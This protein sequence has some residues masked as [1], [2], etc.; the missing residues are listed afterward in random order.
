MEGASGPTFLGR[1]K[2]AAVQADSKGEGGKGGPGYLS[3]LN[4]E[5][6]RGKK[7]SFILLIQFPSGRSG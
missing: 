4:G 5:K 1:R 2:D 7:S 6:L 3:F